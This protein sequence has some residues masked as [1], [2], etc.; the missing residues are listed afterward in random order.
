M[1]P[2]AADIQEATSRESEMRMFEGDRMR[3]EDRNIFKD[4]A[5]FDAWLE[6]MTQ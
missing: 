6:S 5:V 4:T 1:S 3:F 2:G